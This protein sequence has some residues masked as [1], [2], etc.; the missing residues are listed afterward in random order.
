MVKVGNSRATPQH[1]SMPRNTAT[2]M[3]KKYMDIQIK[4][5]KVQST[6]PI[7]TI[8]ACKE[9]SCKVRLEEIQQIEPSFKLQPLDPED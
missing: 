4:L 8:N 9:R 1:S 7:Y 2:A 3:S 5:K 6:K